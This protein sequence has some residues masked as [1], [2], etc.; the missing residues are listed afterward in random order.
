[1]GASLKSFALHP[2]S[3]AQLHRWVIGGDGSGPALMPKIMSSSE[4]ERNNSRV[5][6][7]SDNLPRGSGLFFFFFKFSWLLFISACSWSFSLYFPQII[8]GNLSISLFHLGAHRTMRASGRSL[9]LEFS[10]QTLISRAMAFPASLFP[11]VWESHVCLSLF[12]RKPA[13]GL[14]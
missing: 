10:S 11:P 4:R 9:C 2:G 1:M 12:G 8:S 5:G 14:E 13:C 7:L 6:V 3:S